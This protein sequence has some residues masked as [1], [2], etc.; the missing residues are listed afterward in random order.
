MLTDMTGE[1]NMARLTIDFDRFKD[2]PDLLFDEMRERGVDG[3]IFYQG[4]EIIVSLGVKKAA[5]DSEYYI[6]QK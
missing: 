2:C 6:T 1:L 4:Q 5:N 3:C